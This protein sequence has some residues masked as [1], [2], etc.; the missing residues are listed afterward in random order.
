MLI[1]ISVFESVAA[2]P[3]QGKPEAQLARAVS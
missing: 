2:T 1:T 3:Q